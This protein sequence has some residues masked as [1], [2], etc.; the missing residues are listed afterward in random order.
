MFHNHVYRWWNA[1]FYLAVLA[2][3]GMA[4]IIPLGG[5]T[6]GQ[7]SDKYH[8]P[9]TPAGY[10]FVIWML[11]YLLLAG[12]IVYQFRSVTGKQDS[13]LSISYW[14]I[15]SCIFNIAWIFL[16]Q[17]QYIGL[18][19]AAIIAL[20]LTLAVIYTRTRYIYAPTSGETWLVRLPF[21]IYFGWICTAALV[22]LAVILFHGG[23][24]I[25]PD[26]QS[27]GVI[28]LSAGAA[29]AIGI[30]VR[31]RDGVLPLAFVWAYAAIAVE[32]RSSYGLSMTAAVLSIILLLYALWIGLMRSR[33]RD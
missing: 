24:G 13:V 9:I 16:W 26:L 15:L 6:T 2:V 33:E 1:V 12:Y 10:A 19:F 5:V 22:N 31:P 17:Y 29:A 23:L 14:F 30:T 27:T 8:T 25:S 20:L 4:M 11:I 21:S 3:N 7:L 32:Q 28:L 18:S